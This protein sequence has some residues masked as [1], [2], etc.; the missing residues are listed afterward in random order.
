[1]AHTNGK[2]IAR[3]CVC[4][5]LCSLTFS[6]RHNFRWKICAN[7]QQANV[8]VMSH[9]AKTKVARILYIGRNSHCDEDDFRWASVISRVKYMRM[10]VRLYKHNHLI[11]I[12]YGV[13][14]ARVCGAK[15]SKSSFRLRIFFSFSPVIIPF[16]RNATSFVFHMHKS[17]NSFVFVLSM[18]NLRFLSGFGYDTTCCE[19]ILALIQFLHIC[20]V[21]LA[22]VP[23]H[24]PHHIHILCTQ[25]L[26]FAAHTICV[27]LF[28]FRCRRLHRLFVVTLFFVMLLSLML[29]LLLLFCIIWS[30]ANCTFPITT[31]EME[32]CRER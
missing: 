11:L 29:L 17:Y 27:R 13:H 24:R 19:N 6:T 7:V 9:I 3:L 14:L 22:D 4:L 12:L 28:F 8:N 26:T 25:K 2:F 21:V 23:F 15:A 20:V 10:H 5:Y 32:S 1:M 16:Q 30:S 31:L 18:K